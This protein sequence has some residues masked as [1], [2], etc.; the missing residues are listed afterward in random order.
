LRKNAA[1]HHSK[2]CALMSQ[3]GRPNPA[4]RLASFEGWSDTVR[5]ALIWLGQADPVTSMASAKAEDPE[6]ASFRD[7]MRAWMD[8]IGR[9]WRTR[10]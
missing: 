2:N 1:V 8:A 10:T 6:R 7:L 5:S 9:P 3:M 4:Q